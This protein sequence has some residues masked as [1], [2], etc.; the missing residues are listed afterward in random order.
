[1]WSHVVASD[2]TECDVSSTQVLA[3][4]TNNCVVLGEHCMV[5][6]V[7]SKGRWGPQQCLQIQQLETGASSS[8]DQSQQ[9]VHTL[10]Y[11][12]MLQ[13]PVSGRGRS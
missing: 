7:S 9:Y 2:L 3:H 5:F 13:V 4:I 11:E 6:V 1:M 10:V 8:V 12:G